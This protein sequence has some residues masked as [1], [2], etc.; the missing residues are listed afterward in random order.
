MFALLVKAVCVV[1]VTLAV[2]VAFKSLGHWWGAVVLALPS[3]SVVLLLTRDATPCSVSRSLL[4]LVA[5][6]IFVFVYGHLA[7]RSWPLLGQFVG[8][9]SMYTVTLSG[10][11]WV[12]NIGITGS[13][14]VASLGIGAAIAMNRALSLMQIAGQ[15]K[16]IANTDPAPPLRTSD[17]WLKVVVPLAVV[18]SLQVVEHLAPHLAHFTT[19]FPCATLASFIVM[20][21][22]DSSSAVV[23]LAESIPGTIWVNVVWL[24][25]FG[26]TLHIRE[27]TVGV[28]I[29]VLLAYVVVIPMVI[30]SR[31]SKIINRIRLMPSLI[32]LE[33][34]PFKRGV[35]RASNCS[36]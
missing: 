18:V 1:L 25:V 15:N 2:R 36:V 7:G 13:A 8:A 26:T 20:Q 3:T 19:S 29:P 22:R 16:G 5:T 32:P 27:T 21:K 4:G 9:F 24:V 23:R 12:P 28:I 35:P 14:A 31:P 6:T 10:L 34:M 30:V 17:G 33:R 11:A